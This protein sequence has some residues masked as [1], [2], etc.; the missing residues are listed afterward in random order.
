MKI[1]I[2]AIKT[3]RLIIGYGKRP[4][5]ESI[6]VQLFEGSV[7]AMLG[8]NGAGKSTLIKTLTGEIP[9]LS[10]CV[11][12]FGK[13][14]KHFTRKELAQ[15]ISLVTTDFVQSGALTVRELVSLGRQPHTGFFGRL[16][17]Y[18]RKE[19]QQAMNLVGIE[20]KE[21]SQVSS[22][23]DGERQKSMIARAIAQD[24][25]IVILDEPFSFLD[26]A[27]RVEILSLLINLA[28]EKNT[29]I[30][31]SSHDVSQAIRMADNIMLFSEEGVRTA[32]AADMV[33]NGKISKMFVGRNVIFDPVQ[34]DF[35]SSIK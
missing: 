14:L 7:T 15:T 30:L 31:F 17:E 23:S 35:V 5:A 22:L 9:M 25:P 11:E 19:V 34:N 16:S 1:Q 28:R 24:T 3:S 21:N 32:S 33:T 26:V 12:I 18:D 2:P 10:G 27:S 20:H 8:E 4:V 13:E 6:D 29:T